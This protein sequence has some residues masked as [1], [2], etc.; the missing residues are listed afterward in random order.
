MLNGLQERSL[1]KAGVR[2]SSKLEISGLSENTYLLKVSHLVPNIP[3]NTEVQIT[4]VSLHFAH[5]CSKK[6]VGYRS[7]DLAL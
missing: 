3:V 2:L 4:F 1:A 7:R 6:D 5:L